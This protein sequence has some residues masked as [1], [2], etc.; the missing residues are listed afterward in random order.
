MRLGTAKAEENIAFRRYLAKHHHS[1]KPFQILANEIQQH[2][3][4]TACANCCRYSIVPVTQAEI[5]VIAAHL[6]ETP[7]TVTHLYT[8]PD[9]D[10]QL[11]RLLKSSPDACVFLDNN[12]CMIYEARPKPC[13]EFPHI[14]I[15]TNSLGSRA[16]SHAR[17]AALCP[18]LY[19]AI[20][21]HK[22][23]TGYR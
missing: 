18:I 21:E 14:A 12:L 10:S 4:C 16:S 6:G 19:N 2:V 5:E 17:W 8:D 13:R 15:G 20:E 23:L 22:H 1:D 7:E 11:T 3:D 9:P